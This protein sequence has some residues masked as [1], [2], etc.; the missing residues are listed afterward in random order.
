MWRAGCIDCNAK[1]WKKNHFIK[2]ARVGDRVGTETS[3][4]RLYALDNPTT[5][6]NSAL[7]DK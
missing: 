6:Y 1:G 5:G 2:E 7:N 4:S 3:K